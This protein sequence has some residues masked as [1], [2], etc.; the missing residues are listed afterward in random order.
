MALTPS[1]RTQRARLAAHAM[2][3]Q[4]DSRATTAKGRASFLDRFEREVDPDGTLD[5]VERS[6]RADHAKKAYFARLALKSAQARRVG[7]TA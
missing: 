1:E 5:P 3:A 6:R 7:R 4:N 2:H